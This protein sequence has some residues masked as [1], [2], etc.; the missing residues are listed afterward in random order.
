MAAGGRR[1]VGHLRT[2]GLSSRNFPFQFSTSGFDR[3]VDSVKSFAGKE[4]VKFLVLYQALTTI[5]SQPGKEAG[6][7]GKR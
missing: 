4:R 7:T 1:C 2:V 3:R 5:D 6:K